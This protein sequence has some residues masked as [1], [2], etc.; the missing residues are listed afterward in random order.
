MAVEEVIV[1]SMKKLLIVNAGS[2]SKKYAVY[3]GEAELFRAHFE[4]GE[5]GFMV[6][7]YAGGAHN[8]RAITDTEYTESARRFYED[9][10]AR[11]I[12]KEGEM[13]ALGFRVVAPGEYFN[14]TRSIDP[15]YLKKLQEAYLIA[16][17]H[18]H[19]V[20][21]E[22]SAFFALMPQTQRIGVSDSA[23]HATIPEQAR[24]YALPIEDSKALGIYRYGYH[25]ISVRS[26]LAAVE[27]LLGAVPARVVVCH[28]GSG[29]SVTAI[30]NGA[31]ID[32]SMGFTP[33]EGL[34][35]ATRVG[36]IDAGALIHLGKAKG[37]SYDQL[38]EYCNHECG[39][40]GLSGG[41][42]G[43]VRELLVR[44]A[45]GDTDAKRALDVFTYRIK[46]YIGAYS[47]ALGG[48]D[49]VVFTGTIGERSADIRARVC[50]GLSALGIALDD[51]KNRAVTGDADRLIGLDDMAATIAVVRADE[52]RQIAKETRSFA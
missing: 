34:A 8:T 46:K 25:G 52:M 23:F 35:M 20:M 10:V 22:I 6:T 41:V 48:C 49:A 19:A 50:E 39:L 21:N 42:D 5:N 31:S 38:D 47:A 12:V 40:S 7:E 37:L 14:A 29:A 15:E 3:E 27:R 9:C 16:P 17:L 18:V 30:H 2:A 44:A 1:T 32:T 11:G 51:A 13:S 33:L 26:A 43:G 36:D 45:A 28:L 4:R 24:L